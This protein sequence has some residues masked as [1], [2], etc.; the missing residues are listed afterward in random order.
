M[1]SKTCYIPQV[2]RNV[3]GGTKFVILSENEDNHKV[4][5]QHVAWSD[6]VE[7]E[8]SD[9]VVKCGCDESL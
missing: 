3:Q 4:A 2:A 9:M 5:L 7:S 6:D 1:C 8:T